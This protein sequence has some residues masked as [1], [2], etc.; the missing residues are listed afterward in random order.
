MASSRGRGRGVLSSRQTGDSG[1]QQQAQRKPKTPEDIKGLSGYLT[2]LNHDNLDTYGDMFADMVLGYCSNDRRMQEAVNLI[3]ETTVKDREFAP[4]GA[5]VCRRIIEPGEG[6]NEPIDRTDTRIA[7]RK[8]LL[9]NFQTEYKNKQS[10]RAQSIEAWL[11]IFAFLYEVFFRIQVQGQPIKVVGGAILST[12]SWLLQL[13]DCDDDEVECVCSCLKLVGHL[14]VE[15]NQD[16]VKSIAKL[17]REKAIS[18]KST[19]RVRCLVI[20]VLEYRAF[21]WKDSGGELDQFY[22]DALPDAIAEDELSA[23]S[24]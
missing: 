13:E 7:F 18:R 24:K 4:L 10:I 23:L 12:I 22:C 17:L 2:S 5:K 3:F 21:G 14:L 19:S 6:R 11:A 8:A 16:Q 20:E 9:Q 1:R 15:I